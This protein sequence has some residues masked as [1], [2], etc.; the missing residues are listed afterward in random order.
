MGEVV[1]GTHDRGHGQRVQQGIVVGLALGI[2]LSTSARAVMGHALGH[3]V[4]GIG[5]GRH[6]N[7][8]RRGTWHSGNLG[9]SA[10]L[11]SYSGRAGIKKPPLMVG[12]LVHSLAPA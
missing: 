7:D 11:P 10:V 4:D 6:G 5:I 12:R 2:E 9:G 1:Q 3:G 8:G